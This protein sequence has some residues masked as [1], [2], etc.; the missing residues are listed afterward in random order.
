MGGMP[1]RTAIGQISLCT[2]LFSEACE[3]D[4]MI[5]V[6]VLSEQLSYSWIVS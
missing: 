6:A 3:A 5:A 2:K 1:G 4:N